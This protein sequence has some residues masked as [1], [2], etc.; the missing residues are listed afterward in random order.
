M[1]NMGHWTAVGEYGGYDGCNDGV[2]NFLPC[3]QKYRLKPS[4][5]EPKTITSRAILH[6][7]SIKFCRPGHWYAWLAGGPYFVE[8]YRFWAMEL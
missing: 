1:E 6:Y 5:N 4:T 2:Q 8:R 3:R 7:Q